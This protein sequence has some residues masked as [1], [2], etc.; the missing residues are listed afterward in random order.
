MSEKLLPCPFCG[1]GDLRV[2]GDD[3]WVGA[4]CL[5]CG[6]VG[7]DQYG[8]SND[9]NR[10]TPAPEGEASCIELALVDHLRSLGCVCPKPLV[11]YRPNAGPRCRLCNVEPASPVVPVGVSREELADKVY[12]ILR[13]SNRRP[14]PDHGLI[15]PMDTGAS[16]AIADAI[17]AALTGEDTAGS[18]S[19]QNTEPGLPFSDAGKL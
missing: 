14:S 15:P 16:L 7:P 2:G 3:K 10:R 4:V 17:L 8:S 1:G 19:S 11:G 6:A 5:S 13:H 12:R 18:S 9:W